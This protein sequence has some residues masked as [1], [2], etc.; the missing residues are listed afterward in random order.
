MDFHDILSVESL[1]DGETI[2]NITE[3]LLKL[4][5]GVKLLTPEEAMSALT[6]E[7]FLKKSNLFIKTNA[8]FVPNLVSTCSKVDKLIKR[9]AW[10]GVQDSCPI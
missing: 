1:A 7:A 10:L 4:F 5:I 8:C 6:W 2:K 9:Y 3:D